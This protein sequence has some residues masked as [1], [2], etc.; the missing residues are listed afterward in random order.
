VEQTH[1]D[2][3]VTVVGHG[4]QDVEKALAIAPNLFYKPN[5]SAPVMR[6]YKLNHYLA[7]KPASP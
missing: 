2:Q 4:A 7:I 5:N 3:V 1:Q 6:Y